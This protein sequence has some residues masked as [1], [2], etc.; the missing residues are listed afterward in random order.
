MSVSTEKLIPGLLPPKEGRLEDVD[1]KGIVERFDPSTLS[2]KA[3][4]ELARR[5]PYETQAGVK[6][7]LYNYD[8]KAY[9]VPGDPVA[10]RLS[11]VE[12][13]FKREVEE[14][15]QRNTYKERRT[16]LIAV[17]GVK[18]AVYYVQKQ[19][20]SMSQEDKRE[21]I[22]NLE[23]WERY[24]DQRQQEEADILPEGVPPE[25]YTENYSWRSDEQFIPV[26]SVKMKMLRK[27]TRLVQKDFAKKIGYNI[28]K[29]A[30]LEQGRIKELGFE[31]VDEAFPT[32]LV[33]RIIDLTY[34]NPYW[35]EDDDCIDDVD[36]N[37]TAGSVEE[38][39]CDQYAMYADAAVIRY[40]WS[41]R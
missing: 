28:N 19:A 32:E 7:R 11:F 1:W 37:R 10:R 12:F 6:E 38:A 9:P 13:R 22:E 41:H 40:W 21:E 24:C 5:N 23:R 25:G 15:M 18:A 16:A 3:L 27:G 33:K 26:K 35:F 8:G 30:L 36:E 34:A 14:M 20:E 17:I 29:Y 4:F 31:S 39:T 2:E